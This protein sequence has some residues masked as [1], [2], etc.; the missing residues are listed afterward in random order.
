MQTGTLPAR[1]QG[2][3]PISLRGG[4]SLLRA[5]EESTW[6]T[7]SAVI[8][9]TSRAG[10]LRSARATSSRTNQVVV[11][12]DVTSAN[13]QKPVSMSGRFEVFTSD[14]V[15]SRRATCTESFTIKPFSDGGALKSQYTDAGAIKSHPQVIGRPHFPMFLMRGSQIKRLAPLPAFE[16]ALGS[17][18]L[19]R[20]DEIVYQDVVWSSEWGG[21]PRLQ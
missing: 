15:L 7:W 11:P 2:C 14:F 10:E 8:N 5:L 4:L 1:K 18:L 6:S 21:G 16:E 3:H 19:L 17:G 12:R 20:V 9:L 13:S